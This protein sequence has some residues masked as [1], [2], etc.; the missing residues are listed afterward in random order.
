MSKDITA[1]LKINPNDSGEW[2]IIHC[3]KGLLATCPMR[4]IALKVC[5][6]LT[7]FRKAQ[8]AD[9][10]DRWL[11]Q[12]RQMI[13]DLPK[14]KRKIALHHLDKLLERIAIWKEQKTLNDEVTP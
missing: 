12:L 4:E 13:A 5:V 1:W 7:Y 6:A 8:Q 10:P 11:E 2:E 3:D 14:A 9:A